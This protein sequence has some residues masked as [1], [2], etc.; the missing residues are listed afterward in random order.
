MNHVAYAWHSQLSK[1][2]AAK[3]LRQMQIWVVKLVGGF[4]LLSFHCSWLREIH[5]P[6]EKN[7][8]TFHMQQDTWATTLR[9][10]SQ[11]NLLL[12]LSPPSFPPKASS[13]GPAR[14]RWEHSPSTHTQRK[15]LYLSDVL[16]TARFPGCFSTYYFEDDQL[17]LCKGHLA[18]NFIVTV[19]KWALKQLFKGIPILAATS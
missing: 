1:A 10:I 6:L 9:L 2:A 17:N 11:R 5:N 14:P 16:S 13:T 12:F 8:A 15:S 7:F 3:N 19:V 4:Q 18:N